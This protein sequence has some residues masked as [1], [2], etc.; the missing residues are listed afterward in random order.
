MMSKYSASVVVLMALMRT[1]AAHP[2]PECEPC[3][4]ALPVDLQSLTMAGK[5]RVVRRV[6]SWWVS[7][8]RVVCWPLFFS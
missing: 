5:V 7:W 6:V 3:A 2:Y 4:A 1:A 8:L